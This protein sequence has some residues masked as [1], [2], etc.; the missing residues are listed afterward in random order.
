MIR[1]WTWLVPVLLVGA[2]TAGWSFDGAGRS[3]PPPHARPGLPRIE[4]IAPRNGAVQSAD[5]VV[6]RVKVENFGLAP[7]RFGHAPRLREGHLR[8]SLKR[9]PD[10]VLPE[11]LRRAELSPLGSGR[12]TGRSFDYRR[13]AG[14]N[15]ILAARIGSEGSFSPATKPEIY[16][17]RLPPGFYRL[18]VTLARNDGIALPVHAVTHF[19]I[20]RDRSDPQRRAGK[21]RDCEG[22]VA[23]S[24]AAAE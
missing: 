1:A 10:C 20:P 21:R 9:V 5:A 3:D 24:A 13:F 14:A 8:F 17:R 2:G 19:E 4:V 23:S 6:A 18:V 11:K 22:K 12:L 7:E 15:G 16:Y